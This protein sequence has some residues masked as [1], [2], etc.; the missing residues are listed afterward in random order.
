MSMTNKQRSERLYLDREGQDVFVDISP[1][2]QH[3]I[4][5]VRYL[6]KQF[7]KKRP[8]VILN[9]P[10]GYGKTLQVS[11][12]L[13]AVNNILE[14][15]VLILCENDKAVENWME[16]LKMSTK[17]TDEDII[18]DSPQVY[19][20]KS[21][22]LKRGTNIIPPYARRDWGVVVVKNDFMPR[23][24]LKIQFKATYK[25]WMTTIDMRKDILMFNT[26]YTWLYSEKKRFNVDSFIDAMPSSRQPLNKIKLLDA[27]M[28]DVVTVWNDFTPAKKSEAIQDEIMNTV[29]RVTRKNKDASGTKIKRSKKKVVEDIY[30][31]NVTDNISVNA[32]SNCTVTSMDINTL[33]VGNIK[34]DNG[35]HDLKRDEMDV[36]SSI[37]DRQPIECKEYE[38]MNS[39]TCSQG[40]SFVEAAIDIVK[41]ENVCENNVKNVESAVGDIN[42]VEIKTEQPSDDKKVSNDVNL[43][44]I[45]S[46][47]KEAKSDSPIIPMS[48][49]D[50]V[51][52]INNHFK[53][54]DH[55]K[56]SPVDK[57]K[58]KRDLDYKISEMEE[59]TLKKFKGSLLDSFF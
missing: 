53:D 26:L 24:L 36:D 16:T 28:E 48:I 41:N 49:D 14:D 11:L 10:E 6:Y 25:I 40:I 8:G 32:N 46:D 56:T 59:K 35:V 57:E 2:H 52:K 23:D 43:N 37:N 55:I 17:F 31:V 1:L 50:A 39:E 3:Q 18:I 19:L 12:F 45:S 34:T 30:P 47:N 38:I 22:F 7:K 9:N 21:I 33:E 51:N 42:K 13:N 44:I 27:F 20:R 54:K 15:P 29:K 58:N 4:D 5:G